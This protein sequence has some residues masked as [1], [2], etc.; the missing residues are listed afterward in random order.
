MVQDRRERA[1]QHA[2]VMNMLNEMNA[3]I[4]NGAYDHGL[5]DPIVWLPRAQG[6]H[7]LPDDREDTWGAVTELTVAQLRPYM[8]AY[9]LDARGN[10]DEQLKRLR[11]YIG[12][13][14]SSPNT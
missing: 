11:H 6:A 13:R 8:L 14:L 9:R 1:Q 7:A 2:A 4:T 10:K 3:R 12:L 5:N